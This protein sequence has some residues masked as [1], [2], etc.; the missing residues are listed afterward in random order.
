LPHIPL[1]Q[2]PPA[3]R[4]VCPRRQGGR[5]TWPASTWPRS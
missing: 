2:D 3:W 4:L 1:V 5:A